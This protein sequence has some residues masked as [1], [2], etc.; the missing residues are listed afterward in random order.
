MGVKR[1]ISKLLL[2]HFFAF[3][4]VTD[5]NYSKGAILTNLIFFFLK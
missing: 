3:T 4:Q 2:D 1:Q 5:I